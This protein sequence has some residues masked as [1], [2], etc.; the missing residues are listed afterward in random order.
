MVLCD[1]SERN[2]WGVGVVVLRDFFGIGVELCVETVSSENPSEQQSDGV[3]ALVAIVWVV[4]FGPQRFMVEGRNGLA[5][6]FAGVCGCVA[7]GG[8]VGHVWIGHFDAS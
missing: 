3:V 2:Y 1:A 6:A 4:L 7:G 5:W 8:F